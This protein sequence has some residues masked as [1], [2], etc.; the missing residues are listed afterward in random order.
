MYQNLFQARS[1]GPFK[2]KYSHKHKHSHHPM[3]ERGRGYKTTLTNS[4]FCLYQIR[5]EANIPWR[6]C[7]DPPWSTLTYTDQRKRP[8]LPWRGAA[9]FWSVHRCNNSDFYF[10]AAGQDGLPSCLFTVKSLVYT[11]RHRLLFFL[12]NNVINFLIYTYFT[13]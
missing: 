4:I 12:I 9:L 11:R 13:I 3:P 1:A 6:K 5:V 7:C 2:H 8:N 10:R